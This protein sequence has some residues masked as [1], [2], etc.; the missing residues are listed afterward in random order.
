[1]MIAEKHACGGNPIHSSGFTNVAPARFKSP[2][3]TRWM[4][5]KMKKSLVKRERVVNNKATRGRQILR[6]QRK[7]GELYHPHGIPESSDLRCAAC[8]YTYSAA[9]QDCN[10]QDISRGKVMP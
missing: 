7:R 6:Q 10:R 2:L 4:V 1:M 3:A 9:I 5:D 8:R